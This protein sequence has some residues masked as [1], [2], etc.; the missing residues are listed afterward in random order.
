MIGLGLGILY[1]KTAVGILLGM[2]IG[3][4]AM[5]GVWALFRQK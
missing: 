2:G 5:G 4:I 3:F 1:N